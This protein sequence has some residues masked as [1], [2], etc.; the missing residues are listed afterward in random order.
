MTTSLSIR[1]CPDGNGRHTDGNV[2]HFNRH[3]EAVPRLASSFLLEYPK[4][5]PVHGSNSVLINTN[6]DC[7]L[8]CADHQTYV[9]H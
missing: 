9:A 8:N 2:V 4:S 1:N 3:I 7:S 6:I 5:T